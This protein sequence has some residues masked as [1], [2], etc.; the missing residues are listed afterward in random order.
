MSYLLNDDMFLV[1]WF[2]VVRLLV[3]F[4]EPRCG[5]WSGLL[6]LLGDFL[7]RRLERGVSGLSL[8]LRMEKKVGSEV[9]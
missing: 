5:L 9:T 6:S 8:V 4:P 7:F 2:G 3:R 1:S